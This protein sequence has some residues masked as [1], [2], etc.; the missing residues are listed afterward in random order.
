MHLVRA[1]A[2]EGFAPLVNSL[3]KNPAGLLRAAG[4][5]PSV[6]RQPDMYLP[7]DRVADL[8]RLSAAHC[9]D[10]LF[11]LKLVS[12]QGR[13]TIGVLGLFM[14]FQ[15]TIGDSLEFAKRY[16]HLHASGAILRQVDL[17]KLTQIEMDFDLPEAIGLDQLRQASIGL[18][19]RVMQKLGEGCLP[20]CEVL[21]QQAEPVSGWESAEEF[22]GCPVKFRAETDGIV[23]RVDVLESPPQTAGGQLQQ[24]LRKHLRSLEEDFPG[25]LVAQVRH[26]IDALLSTHECTLENVAMLLSR[27]PRVLQKQLAENGTQFR[28]LLE[29]TRMKIAMQHLRHSGISL[30]ELALNLGFAELAVF[31]R[32]F[33][34]WS[35]RSPLKWR[36]EFRQNSATSWR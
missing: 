28:R 3:G 23:F 9:N 6:L 26:T 10:E 7:Y 36:Q 14:S 15:P 35:G 13:R 29:E 8:L 5:N 31:S 11:G 24:H 34:R 1:G 12:R 4:L 32:A 17:G 33:K 25:N 16:I 19:H 22:F 18:L 20:P 27:H 2:L 30:T 21:L